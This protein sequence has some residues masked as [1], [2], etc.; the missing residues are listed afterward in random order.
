MDKGATIAYFCFAF[1]HICDHG[2]LMDGLLRSVDH[3]ILT[4]LVM[5]KVSIPTASYCDTFLV[6]LVGFP[7]IYAVPQILNFCTPPQISGACYFFRIYVEGSMMDNRGGSM[8][9]TCF[10]HKRHS[11]AQR[12]SQIHHKNT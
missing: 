4:Q 5:E 2:L 6:T 3:L 11:I 1:L 8:M 9:D 7:H 10:L 12:G